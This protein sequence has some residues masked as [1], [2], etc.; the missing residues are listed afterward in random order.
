MGEASAADWVTAIGTMLAGLAA[1]A[2]VV[3]GGLTARAWRAQAR[4]AK[5]AEVAG[6]A[7]IAA[8]QY[9][10]A[11]ERM[12]HG[13]RRDTPDMAD[14]VHAR[15]EETEP[16]ESVLRAAVVRAT[17]FLPDD[18]VDLLLEV[19][20][21]GTTLHG[22]QWAYGLEHD[23]GVEQSAGRFMEVFG[24]GQRASLGSLRTRVLTMLKPIARVEAPRSRH[25]PG[26]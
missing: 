12:R 18:T 2:A 8:L 4:T 23:A 11:I 10:A 1:V 13:Y 7:L 25:R 24:P 9:I 22:E 5:E 26:P 19:V 14:R 3:L 20:D 6:E 21:H 17:A 16:A 15:W